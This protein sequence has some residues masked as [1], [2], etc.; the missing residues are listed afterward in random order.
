VRLILLGP[1]GA[2][3]GTQAAAIRERYGVPHI[4]TGDIL[5]EAIAAGTPLGRIVRSIVESGSLVPD[6]VIGEVVADRLSRDDARKGFLLDGFPRT[7]RQ[8]EILDAMLK[9]RREQLT[10]VISLEL[11]DD[12]VVKRLSGR[13]T[14]T[15]CGALHHVDYSPSRAEGICDACGGKSERREDDKEDSVRT[16]IREYHVKTAPL[17]GLYS[18][19]GLLR[20][21]D[22]AGSVDEVTRR[23]AVAVEGP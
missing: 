13:R 14:C 18:D 5:R 2:G 4:S 1:P 21:V 15:S 19:L 11:S 8:A 12:E 23:V 7:L 6:E 20:V 9:A 3:K 22:G 17:S 10:A 16:R